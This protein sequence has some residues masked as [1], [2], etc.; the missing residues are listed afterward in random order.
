MRLSLFIFPV[1]RHDG[2]A[3]WQCLFWDCWYSP[4]PVKNFKLPVLTLI[5]GVFIAAFGWLFIAYQD[6]D[7]VFVVSGRS[8]M[9]VFTL[10]IVGIAGLVGAMCHERDTRIQAYISAHQMFGYP[11][12]GLCCLVLLGNLLLGT[13]T[14]I[15]ATRD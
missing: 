6:P 7:G 12:L 14:I 10:V 4:D 11:E 13:L 5:C 2:R 3:C 9:T 15:D 1:S 8:G